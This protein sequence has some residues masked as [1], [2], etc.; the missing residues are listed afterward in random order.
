MRV[1]T[2]PRA[3]TRTSP[4]GDRARDGGDGPG[5]A[6][7]VASAQAVV[8]S[9][10]ATRAVSAALAGALVCG[11]VALLVAAG[12]RQQPV[13]PAPAAATVDTSGQAGAQEL[14]VRVVVTWLTATRG[15]EDLLTPLVAGP[16][17]LPATPFQVRDPVV[18]DVTHTRG[19]VWSVTVAA[20]VTDGAGVTA[21]RYYLVPVAVH[22][23]SAQALTGPTPVAGRALGGAP[24]TDYPQHLDP[25]GPVAQSVAGF[26]TAYTAGGGDPARY[27]SPGVV[28]PAIVPAPYTAVSLRS[29]DARQELADQ[30]TPG[31]GDQVQ[32]LVAAQGQ[33]TPTQEV[34][35]TYALT[36]HARGGRWEVAAIDPAPVT[37]TGPTSGLTTGQPYTQ[38]VT[39]NPGP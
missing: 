31:D 9:T 11:P 4:A 10:W 28:L 35:L 16:V 19:G 8:A 27:T 29:V 34:S 36:L 39:P 20:T 3:R 21:R 12:G 22:D 26:L 24:A 5:R 18:A 7:P 14:A 15:Q 13:P 23:G 30:A 32:V 38:T 17:T 37:G 2:L 25:A 6:A 33:V 1:P